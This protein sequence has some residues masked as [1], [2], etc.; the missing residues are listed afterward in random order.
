MSQQ[1]GAQFGGV[2]TGLG[3][4][5]SQVGDIFH[6]SPIMRIGVIHSAVV[7]MLTYELCGSLRVTAGNLETMDTLAGTGLI[8]YTH[9]Y[10]H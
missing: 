7:H 1:S 10:R 4:D 3:V 5:G 2:T 8:V 6:I 9:R